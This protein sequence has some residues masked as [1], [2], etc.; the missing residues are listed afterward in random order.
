M[1]HSNPMRVPRG[2]MHERLE[3][4]IRQRPETTAY[5]LGEPVRDPLQHG[6]DELLVPV[7][8]DGGL[9]SYLP[10]PDGSEENVAISGHL[11]QELVMEDSGP[12][13]R[14]PKHD[15]EL[16]PRTISHVASWTCPGD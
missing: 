16:I 13:P 6:N 14:C 2:R 9:A 3:H 12:W 7:L 8:L 4:D 15:H 10:W 5:R 1:E 11:I